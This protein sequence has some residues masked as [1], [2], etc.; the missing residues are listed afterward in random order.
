MKSRIHLAAGVLTFMMAGLWAAA[1][2]APDQRLQTDHRRAAAQSGSGRLG[3]L[4]PHPRRLGVQPAEPDQPAECRPAPARVVVGH[5]A[6]LQPADAARLQRHHVSPQPEQHRAGARRRHGRSALGISPGVSGGAG[7]GPAG[8]RRRRPPA[9]K[10]RDLGRQDLHQHRRRAHRRAQRPHRRDRVGHDRRR[11]EQGVRLHE[12]ADHR[13]RQGRRGHDRLLALQGRHLLHHRSRRQDRQGA[14]AHLH[15]RAARRAGRRHVG[16][17]AAGL[18]RRRRRLDP[19]QLRPHHEP[20]LLGDRAG[21]ALGARGAR[22]RRRRA[23]HEF[24]AGARSGHRQDRLVLPAP[25]GRIARHG[26]SVRKHPRRQRRPAV[27]LQDG[28][29]RGAVGARSQ[30]RQVPQ[31]LRSGLSDADEHRSDDG[32]GHVSPGA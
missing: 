7:P 14:V 5:A 25:A 17:S 6:G 18:P 9:A 21:Q 30:D 29:D 19:R 10:P 8:R 24:H 16:R 32:Q 28:Q 20:D 3:E 2:S 13:E 22:H 15:G 12:R 31:R 11:S 1:Q 4:A 23:L 26:R 27:A